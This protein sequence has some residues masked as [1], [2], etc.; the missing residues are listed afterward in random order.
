MFSNFKSGQIFRKTL[1]KEKTTTYVCENLQ[2]GL[3]PA[4]VPFKN[5]H[6]VISAVTEGF[7]KGAQA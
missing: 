5:N 6:K 4:V 3:A 2:T 1:I 7:I